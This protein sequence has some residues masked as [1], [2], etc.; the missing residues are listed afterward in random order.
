MSLSAVHF[1]STEKQSGSDL[2][3]YADAPM[4]NMMAWFL[5]AE[6]YLGV[7]HRALTSTLLY[8]FGINGPV[9][10]DRFH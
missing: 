3:L 10:R 7:L 2:F 1:P 6:D 5:Q 9:I 4:H 8:T